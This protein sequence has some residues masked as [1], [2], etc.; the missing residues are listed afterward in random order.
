[1]FNIFPPFLTRWNLTI[2]PEQPLLIHR[3][4]G[5]EKRDAERN[6][7]ATMIY[8]VPELCY[9]TGQTE[10][11]RKDFS[12][13]RELAKFTRPDPTARV[14]HI[15][16]FNEAMR[17]E[18][19]QNT[20]Q[21]W[22]VE[23]QRDLTRAENVR[24]LRPETVLFKRSDLDLPDKQTGWNLI[25][26]DWNQMPDAFFQ[27]AAYSPWAMVATQRDMPD[28]R[29]FTDLM[30]RQK[31]GFSIESPSECISVPTPRDYASYLRELCKRRSDLLMVLVFIPPK[32]DDAYFT[33]K[34]VL[35]REHGI[36][37]QVVIAD[38]KITRQHAQDRKCHSV[39]GKVM[40]QMLVKVGGIPWILRNPLKKAMIIGIDVFHDP[41]RKEESVVGFVATMDS[42]WCRSV[43]M[44]HVINGMIRSKNIGRAYGEMDHGS[45]SFDF[46]SVLRRYW[47]KTKKQDLVSDELTVEIKS[48]A[49]EAF[50]EFHRQN[51]QM[52]AKV[53]VYRDGVGEGQLQV[54]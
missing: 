14:Q 45:L 1:M 36:P 30:T 17:R 49:I 47:S 13:Q 51:N 16:G 44:F 31:F 9:Q 7:K 21:P 46:E 2:R 18:E 52:P 24:V 4:K 25:N 26:P 12:L 27:V 29:N 5:S 11:M 32:N 37:S 48:L 34:S 42:E 23:L 33:I 15:E 20:L 40:L 28:A 38:R 35:S 53:I 8:L 19:A 43:I 39:A 54:I 3:L 41:K 50:K 10:E 22:G 6:G